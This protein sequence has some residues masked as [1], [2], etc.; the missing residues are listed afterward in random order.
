M[1]I[2][3]LGLGLNGTPVGGGS[4]PAPTIYRT[5]GWHDNGYRSYDPAQ[6]WLDIMKTAQWNYSG[7][8]PAQDAK[9]WPTGMP[10]G[11]GNYNILWD[12]W[13]EAR[14][15]DLAS[16][17]YTLT[18]DGVGTVVD[19]SGL[20]NWTVVDSNTVTFD[21][22]T[23]GP[24]N[25]QFAITSID[26]ADP[27]RNIKV[28]KTD[29]VA[30]YN[31]GQ[32]F[33]PEFIEK[34]EV[35]TIKRFMSNMISGVTDWGEAIPTDDW[36]N[37]QKNVPPEEICRMCNEAGVD[38][39]ITLNP[40]VGQ[41]GIEEWA[42]RIAATLDTDRTIY[43]AW[44]N[45]TWNTG[46][47]AYRDYCIVGGVREWGEV[48]L[49][50]I[51][52]TNGSPVVTMDD[53][54]GIL[55]E[56]VGQGSCFVVDEAEITQTYQ[57]KFY[58]VLSVDSAT[59]ITL[60][61]DYAGANDTGLTG[62]WA[63]NSTT[64]LLDEFHSKR[65]YEHIKIFIDQLT[66]EGSTHTVYK[67][68]EG[69]SSSAGGVNDRRL[70][71]PNW[72]GDVDYVDPKTY[73][74]GFAITYY[75]GSGIQS[76][77]IYTDTITT[78]NGGAGDIAQARAD[79]HDY[80]QDPTQDLGNGVGLWQM[81]DWMIQNRD[82]ISGTG[83][84]LITYEGGTHV[85]GAEGGAQ[86]ANFVE[87]YN[88]HYFDTPQIAQDIELAYQMCI[89]ELD[90]P[91]L[92]LGMIG[93]HSSSGTWGTWRFNSDTNTSATK[94][95][96][97]AQ[98]TAPWYG[99]GVA[100]QVAVT[101]ANSQIEGMTVDQYTNPSARMKRAV[102]AGFSSQKYAPGASWS[103]SDNDPALTI[104]SSTGDLGGYFNLTGSQSFAVN[105]TVNG[106]TVSQT[107][108]YTASAV[109]VADMDQFD[110]NGGAYALCTSSGSNSGELTETIAFFFGGMV[111][112]DLS[113]MGAGSSDY[114]FADVGIKHLL[115]FD[116]SGNLRFATSWTDSG[117]IY[118][119]IIVPAA[120]ILSRTCDVY[121]LFNAFTNNYDV[122][123]D[124]GGTVAT[125][126]NTGTATGAYFN[127]GIRNQ[128]AI[129]NNTSDIYPIGNVQMDR[130]AMWD[131]VVLD[132]SDPAGRTIVKNRALSGTVGRQLFD[133]YGADGAWANQV[134]GGDTITWIP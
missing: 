11:G 24:A 103:L 93:A 133:F 128:Y 118:N 30:L 26:G 105:L 20:S 32:R 117:F 134:S 67:I 89:A 54:T 119:D 95:T 40:K 2:L 125:F 62:S 132:F 86:D 60:T 4:G 109:S 68:L 78:Y 49:T 92:K 17:N 110:F 3:R 47:A 58:N 96:E 6:P 12:N 102:K 88:D 43:V 56:G 64:G 121:M 59:Q 114:L 98:N 71:P 70:N 131:N 27:M 85:I 122:Y 99:S 79:M 38:P 21:M 31:A 126:N 104:D 5:L 94:Y 25:K 1:G 8:F 45:E 50:G 124:T 74:D 97:L 91:P 75:W 48:Q 55:P 101:F 115:R 129:G 42:T 84:D 127:E 112:P 65:S 44:A 76:Y 77:S 107:C 34:V 29:Q 7:D 36:Y 35:A 72:S 83:L 33:R 46:R 57:P 116:S 14:L 15:G 51:T 23:S 87:F 16:A 13:T 22:D 28:I 100:P 69:Q 106:S 81:Y 39:Y 73:Y 82:L 9:G 113:G 41:A 63:G 52:V 19:G 37:Y 80:L 61:E 111:I 120:D 66:A 18:W 130:A 123:V 108:N 53:T 10:T 90:L